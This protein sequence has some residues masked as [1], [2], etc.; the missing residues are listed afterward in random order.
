MELVGGFDPFEQ[1]ESKWKPSPN[2][3]MKI[4]N[5]WNLEKEIHELEGSIRPS[6]SRKV[7]RL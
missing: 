2:F 1:Y 4:K 3:G 6:N 5:L 7:K